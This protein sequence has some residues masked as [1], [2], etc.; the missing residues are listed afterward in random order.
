MKPRCSPPSASRWLGHRPLERV[1]HARV[2]G[3]HLGK[4]ARVQV[5]DDRVGRRRARVDRG[6]DVDGS[7]PVDAPD[8]REPAPGLDDRD[9][10]ERHLATVRCP[11]TH[12]PEVAERAA[13]VARIAHHDAYVVAAPLD[14]L[15]LLAVERLAHLAPKALEGEADGFGRRLDAELHLLLAGAERVGHLVDAGVASEAPLDLVRRSPQHVD[16]RSGE[17]HVDIAA[18]THRA[19]REVDRDRFRDR[20]RRVA[21][22]QAEFL[23]A[24]DA[25]FRREQLYRHLA[26]VRRRE[27]PDRGTRGTTAPRRHRPVAHRRQHVPEVVPAGLLEQPAAGAEPR[28]ARASRPPPPWPSTRRTLRHRHRG[29]DDVRLDRRHE[30]EAGTPRQHHP[31]GDD[32]H[33]TPTA[34]VTYRHCSADSSTGP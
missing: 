13:L 14:A 23:A 16:I 2:A 33:P 6:G 26:R 8:R 22:K 10:A 4:D 25:R 21:Q 15:R 11:D 31:D 27:A 30:A 17:L 28:P 3:Q 5:G 1:E 20:L 12:V 32:H 18:R 7:V 24:V 34:A 9:L 29:R 19:Q